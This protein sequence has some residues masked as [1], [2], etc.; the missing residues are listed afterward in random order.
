MI[1]NIQ[2]VERSSL[3]AKILS[4]FFFLAISSLYLFPNT[5]TNMYKPILIILLTFILILQNSKLKIN[6]ISV[7]V[8]ISV[9][10]YSIVFL[11]NISFRSFI[12]FAS[13]LLPLIIILILS[14]LKFS[15]KDLEVIINSIYMGSVFFAFC[16]LVS[17]PDITAMS[18]MYRTEIKY[19]NTTINANG[20]SY[21]TVPAILIGF[22][23]INLSSNRNKIK[24]IILM[25]ILLYPIFYSMSRG[26]FLSLFLGTLL[27]IIHYIKY[28]SIKINITKIVS[29]I[30]FVCILVLLVYNILPQNIGDR[31]FNFSSYELNSRDILWKQAFDLAKNNII[32]GSG[33]TYYW[34]KTGNDYG[35]HN[36]YIDLLVST[37]I[38]GSV[39][40]LLIL[41]IIVIKSKNNFILFSFLVTAFVNSMVESG[42]SYSFWIPIMLIIMIINSEDNNR[43]IKEIF[44]PRYR[45][46]KKINA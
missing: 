2:V 43:D 44:K 25:C 39:L 4:I 30:F 38:I 17:N 20:I 35:S 40:M 13:T 19:F 45:N 33:Y 15:R 11:M 42:R 29:L 24:H 14:T 22:H 41:F 6:L 21:I 9:V 46:V 34:E 27:I 3:K 18:A 10:Y 12:P 26:G 36:L 8:T 32:F 28:Y 31:L 23:K 7:I 16:I 5:I 1:N 37:G